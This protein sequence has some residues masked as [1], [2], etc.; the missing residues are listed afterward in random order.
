MNKEL[1]SYDDS[2]YIEQSIAYSIDVQLNR[3]TSPEE[4]ERI[5]SNIFDFYYTR[6]LHSFFILSNLE[7]MS[8]SIFTNEEFRSFILEVCEHFS[9][10]ISRKGLKRETIIDT[11]V[12]SICSTRIDIK[13]TNMSLIN[14]NINLAMYVNSEVLRSCLKDNFWLIVLYFMI[15]Y[16]KETQVYKDFIEDNKPK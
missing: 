9:F 3:I 15:I 16:L 11:I 8:S 5:V 6:K 7:N 10:W 12:E 4:L 2:K 13:E 14:E 1:I